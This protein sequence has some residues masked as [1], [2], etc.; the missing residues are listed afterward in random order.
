VVGG[1]DFRLK[2]RSNHDLCGSQL[3][4][5]RRRGVLVFLNLYTD[6]RRLVL[7][8]ITRERQK[9]LLQQVLS[10]RTLRTLTCA[11]APITRDESRAHAHELTSAGLATTPPMHTSVSSS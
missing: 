4:V 11:G 9:V 10:S 8:V 7:L 5:H 3:Y 2:G 1:N 6:L